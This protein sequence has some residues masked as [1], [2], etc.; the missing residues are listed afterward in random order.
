VPPRLTAPSDHIEQLRNPL[1]EDVEPDSIDLILMGRTFDQPLGK[2][3]D[4]P[5][6]P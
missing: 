1:K 5:K 6:Q 3:L 2:T 4:G